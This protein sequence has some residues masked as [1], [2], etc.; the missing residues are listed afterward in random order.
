MN[1][2][3]NTKP[4]I[5]QISIPLSAHIQAEKFRRY[6]SQSSKA[7]QV[8]LNTLAVATVNSYLNRIGWATNLEQSDSW[9]PVTQIMMDVADLKIPSYG[10]LECRPILCGQDRVMIPAEVWT[11]RIGYM[12]VMLDNSLTRG[13]LIGFVR[14]VNQ[15][16]LPLTRLESIAK[17]PTYL[18]QQKRATPAQVASLSSWISG[19]LAQGWQQLDELFAPQMVINFRSRRNFA[20]SLVSLD[21]PDISKVK[22]VQLG[23]DASQTIA[24]ILDIQPQSE[25]EFSVS[26]RV[27]NHEYNN[28]LPEGLELVI[29]DQTNRPVMVAQASETETIEFVFSGELGEKFSVEISLDEDIQVENFTI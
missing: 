26:V 11:D 4:E 18:C 13:K 27:C 20:Q 14:Q 25:S 3:P 8:Y 16:E 29:I 21:A 24:L 17:F 12:V 6:Q 28:Y 15:S 10:K 19:A 9:N 1:L 2:P 22:L 7:R 5:F 23:K